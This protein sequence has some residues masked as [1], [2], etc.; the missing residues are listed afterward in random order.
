MVTAQAVC[1]HEGGKSSTSINKL[2]MLFTGKVTLVQRHFPR[3]LRSVGVGLLLAGV[4]LRA[5]G[6][7]LVSSASPTRQGRP[8]TSGEDWRALWAMRDQWRGGWTG[9]GPHRVANRLCFGP[10]V[11]FPLSSRGMRIHVP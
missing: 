1:E 2:L 3:V 5:A 10:Q 9:N 6:T 7:R 4:G 8:T 11:P